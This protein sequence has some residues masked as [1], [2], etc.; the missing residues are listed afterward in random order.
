[1][2]SS[3]SQFSDLDEDTK[4]IALANNRNAEHAILLFMD[5]SNVWSVGYGFSGSGS[6]RDERHGQNFRTTLDKATKLPDGAKEVVAH[7]FETLQGALYTSDY[8]LAN[9]EQEAHIIW[10]GLL[11]NDIKQRAVSYT[12]LTLPTKRIV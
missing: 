3:Y 10:A 1:M 4:V 7:A 9:W 8:L 11:N 5:G 12:H 2:V 6:Q